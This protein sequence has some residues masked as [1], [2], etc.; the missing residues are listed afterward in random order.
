MYT[1]VD[2]VDEYGDVFRIADT[3]KESNLN[4]ARDL[5][6]TMLQNF[7]LGKYIKLKNLPLPVAK[8]THNTAATFPF[9]TTIITEVISDEVI[10]EE[11]IKSQ[12][13]STPQAL[14]ERA[15]KNPADA[16]LPRES[17]LGII[18][19]EDTPPKGDAPG[20]IRFLAFDERVHT[21][22][23]VVFMLLDMSKK[24]E[25]NCV[26]FDHTQ[27]PFPKTTLC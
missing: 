4:K 5:R 15:K 2:L 24:C 23:Y 22:R 13:C 3:T 18:M 19:G 27:F 6:K 8:S 14:Y 16:P 20:V 1:R 12:Y 7:P 26:I 25:C 17:V 21:V 11:Q 10:F 9:A